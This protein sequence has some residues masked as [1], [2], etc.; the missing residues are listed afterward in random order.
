M[1]LFLTAAI[2]ACTSHL[3]LADEWCPKYKDKNPSAV[4]D[5]GEYKMFYFTDGTFYSEVEQPAIVLLTKNQTV[6]TTTEASGISDY[7][8]STEYTGNSTGMGCD[9][10]LLT[11]EYAWFHD[12]NGKTQNFYTGYVRAP[13]HKVHTLTCAP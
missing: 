9:S 1:K 11:F 10:V 12:E 7:Y 4:V 5:M 13:D 6:L 3:A 8:Q 2:L